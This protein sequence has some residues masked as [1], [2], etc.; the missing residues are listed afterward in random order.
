MSNVLIIS[1]SGGGGHIHAARARHAQI[2]KKTPNAKIWEVNIL[3]DWLGKRFGNYFTNVWNMAQRKGQL[4]VLKSLSGGQAF[5]DIL[6]FLP[7]FYRTYQFLKTH[8]I[9]RVL[10]TQP[11]GLSAIIK[12]IRLYERRSGKSIILEKVIIELPTDKTHLYFGTLRR[13]SKKD[14]NKLHL[15][16]LPPL[17][18]QVSTDELF[19][20]K[21]CKLDPHLVKYEALPIRLSFSKKTYPRTLKIALHEKNEIVMMRKTVDERFPIEGKELV[22]R[23]K[24]TDTVYTLMLGSNPAEEAT[25]KYARLFMQTIDL[26]PGNS[27]HFLF[28]CCADGHLLRDM[29]HLARKAKKLIILPMS[30]QD[31]TVIAPLYHHSRATLTRSGAITSMELLTRARG[32]IFIHSETKHKSLTL[33]R[34]LKGMPTWEGGNAEYL[35]EKK[36]AEVVT[37]ETFD[38]RI[39]YLTSPDQSS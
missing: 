1:S 38:Q 37:P 31:D 18:R 8:D 19:W 15:H 17:L 12:A 10:D 14:R 22:V 26:L 28:A 27:R 23:L 13:L 36:G 30:Y 7:I 21:F 3:V 5:A 2:L 4:F 9:D 24:P 35:M 32:Q 16:T 6:F 39:K 11:L 33:S 29:H 25:L 34:L 20:K